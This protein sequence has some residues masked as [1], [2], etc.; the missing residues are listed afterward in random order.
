MSPETIATK[1][2]EYL[3]YLGDNAPTPINFA[4]DRSE[5]HRKI[6]AIKSWEHDVALNIQTAD[7]AKSVY[8]VLAAEAIAE[9]K[10]VI[11]QYQEFFSWSRI[12]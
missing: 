11:N 10:S 7:D 1:F 9:V 8:S 4:W 3:Q 2:F 6:E 12:C 5:L